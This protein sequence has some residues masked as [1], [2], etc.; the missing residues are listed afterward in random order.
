MSS[1]PTKQ[2]AAARR[3]WVILLYFYIA[4]LV[5]LGFLITGTTTALFGAKSLALP[6]LTIRSYEYESTLRRD[7]QQ[8]TVIATD[9]EREAARQ[10]AIDDKRREGLDDVTDGAILIVVGAPT[11]FW[12]LRRA[13][14]IGAWPEPAGPSGPSPAPATDQP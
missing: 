12:H 11:L 3:P 7:P 5:G 4:A 9:A 1:T 6:E 14:R 10:R 13:R 2:S 8:G